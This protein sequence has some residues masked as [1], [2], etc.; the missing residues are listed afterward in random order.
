[1]VGGGTRVSISPL[2]E[3]CEED[4]LPLSSAAPGAHGPS[5]AGPCAFRNLRQAPDVLS[6]RPQATLLAPRF[7][8]RPSPPCQFPSSHHMSTVT[9]F[10]AP[11]PVLHS[12]RFPR[13]LSTWMAFF[14]DA[15]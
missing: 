4:P 15:S 6:R 10:N 5:Q 2:P 12:T 13:S 14:S 7:S 8:S 9:T 11:S 3:S 1:M